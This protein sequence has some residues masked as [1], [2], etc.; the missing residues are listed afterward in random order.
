MASVA[1][2][3]G[4][5]HS[6]RFALAEYASYGVLPAAAGATYSKSKIKLRDCKSGLE[7][8]IHAVRI[9]VVFQSDPGAGG[10]WFLRALARYSLQL[11]SDL[12]A[13]I[14]ACWALRRYLWSSKLISSSRLIW[15]RRNGGNWNM[16]A[17]ANPATTLVGGISFTAGSNT[18]KAV[19]P[20]STSDRS[21]SLLLA[22]LHMRTP[23]RPVLHNQ[24]PAAP[25]VPVLT[26][27]ATFNEYAFGWHC[28]VEWKLDGNAGTTNN[29]A[30]AF[31][32]T[33]LT[34]GKYYFE[35]TASGLYA[36]RLAQIRH[37]V[38]DGNAYWHMSGNDNKCMIAVPGAN[39]FIYTNGASTG[40]NIGI[41]RSRKCFRFCD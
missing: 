28:Y 16:S 39:T 32:T 11:T 4:F 12:Q 34:T 36:W 40:K 37:H 1:I 26:N 30:G 24:L 25:S 20:V 9:N 2:F 17:P 27:F 7:S 31:S 5:S 23:H 15:F 8:G 13:L 29:A 18:P 10:C 19:L 14:L 35:V 22:R 3:N 21:R 41:C 33:Y 38:I 6:V